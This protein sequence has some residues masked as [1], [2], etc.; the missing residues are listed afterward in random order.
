M[1]DRIA[2]LAT[3]NG[4]DFTVYMDDICLSGALASRKMLFE[5]RGIIARNGLRSHKCKFFP[6][7][8]PR[9]VT[10]VALTASGYRLPHRRHLK[11]HEALVQLKS[12]PSGTAYERELHATMSRMSEAAQLEPVWRERVR[13]LRASY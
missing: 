11:I 2:D 9:V 6:S 3:E 13:S 8:I 4:L 1:F 12:L 7:G 10:G 5:V